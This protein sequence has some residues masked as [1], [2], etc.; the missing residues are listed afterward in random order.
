MSQQAPGFSPAS[1]NPLSAALAEQLVAITPRG[2]EM[3]FFTN[4]GA[5]S[6]EAALKLARAATG[7]SGLLS[8]LGSF[9]G[10]TFGALSVTGNRTYQRPFGPLVPDCQ[11]IPYGDLQAL[12]TALATRQYAAFVVE[13]IQGEGGM[14]DAAAGLSAPKPNGSAAMPARCSS[15]TRCRPDWDGPGRCSRL[16]GKGSSPTS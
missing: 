2:L 3:V 10:K 12:E 1:V 9:H 16:S 14:V 13:P 8:C 5:E 11:S 4:S 15:L 7:R 6:V